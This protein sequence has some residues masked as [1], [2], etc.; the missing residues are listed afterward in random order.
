MTLATLL[1][2]EEP[3]TSDMNS[4]LVSKLLQKKTLKVENNTFNK[5]YRDT[6]LN[7]LGK[8]NRC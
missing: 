2:K 6:L 5:N 3:K 7:D 8:V 1:E 4:Q